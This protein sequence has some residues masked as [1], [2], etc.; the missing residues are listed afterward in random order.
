MCVRLRYAGLFAPYGGGSLW[1][2][3]NAEQRK[4]GAE[5]AGPVRVPDLKQPTAEMHEM[6]FH[7]QTMRAAD[8]L[9]APL[10]DPST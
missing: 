10:W 8:H 5:T 4:G 1:G 6:D 9:A 3:W 7:P 2:W